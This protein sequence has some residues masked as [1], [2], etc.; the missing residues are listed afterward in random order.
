MNYLMKTFLKS[1]S[2]TKPDHFLV[3]FLI[4]KRSEFS[5]FYPYDFHANF[6]TLASRDYPAFE[7]D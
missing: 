4:K 6:Q 1:L 5:V 7:G 3:N 2:P